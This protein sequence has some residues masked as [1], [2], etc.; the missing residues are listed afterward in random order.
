M[1]DI[2]T[3]A[4]E[5]IVSSRSLSQHWLVKIPS[6]GKGTHQQCHGPLWARCCVVRWI[7]GKKCTGHCICF[8]Q[9]PN[10]TGTKSVITAYQLAIIAQRL[11]YSNSWSVIVRTWNP[12]DGIHNGM[13][14]LHLICQQFVLPSLRTAGINMWI[15]AQDEPNQT[16]WLWQ[17]WNGFN[18]DSSI[19]M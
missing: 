11:N 18:K 15:Q 6:K 17:H 5:T 9:H 8:T 14:S 2:T 13:C 10:F 3:W 12:T 7:G 19:Q 16:S 4:Q 1:W